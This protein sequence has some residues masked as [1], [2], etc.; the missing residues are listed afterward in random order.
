M[1]TKEQL[2]KNIDEC[3][4]TG[5]LML[6]ELTN[7]G[8]KDM[9]RQVEQCLRFFRLCEPAKTSRYLNKHHVEEIVRRHVQRETLGV[10]I[11]Q[12]GVWQDKSAYVC[13]EALGHAAK[14]AGILSHRDGPDPEAYVY[15]FLIFPKTCRLCAYV[16]D[17]PEDR[18]PGIVPLGKKET[19]CVKLNKYN[20]PTCKF[21]NGKVT[22]IWPGDKKKPGMA[23]YQE[24]SMKEFIREPVKNAQEERI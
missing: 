9:D 10:K 8:M 7:N 15:V 17:S 18:F 1:I 23:D 13:K 16:Q 24:W 22:T 11:K 4:S 12:Y 3:L 5:R 6:E 2:N 20:L 21:V 14:L 19:C